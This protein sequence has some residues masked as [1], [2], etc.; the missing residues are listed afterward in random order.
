MNEIS[1]LL[2]RLFR[3]FDASGFN[4]HV[5][6]FVFAWR[7][8]PRPNLPPKSRNCRRRAPFIPIEASGRPKHHQ[9]TFPVSYFHNHKSVD[10]F[11]PSHLNAASINKLSHRASRPKKY[12]VRPVRPRGSPERFVPFAPEDLPDRF[13]VMKRQE[14]S[15]Y[16]VEDYLNPNYQVPRAAPTDLM[17]MPSSDAESSTSSTYSVGTDSSAAGVNEQWRSRICEWSYQVIDH[18]DYDREI[19]AVSL[20]YLDRYL[21]KRPVNKR[22]FQLVAMTTLY[23]AC[24][25]YDPNKL[26][27]SSLIEL[28]RGYFTEEHITAMEGS[29]LK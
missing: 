20:S 13:Q 19:V 24:K 9:S 8:A 4:F 3:R 16:K 2:P 1:F 22:T 28:S 15:A 25:L 21:C 23:L 11:V 26:R 27:M 12:H 6:F 10:C 17:C 14:V 29:I 18:F 7:I 5:S